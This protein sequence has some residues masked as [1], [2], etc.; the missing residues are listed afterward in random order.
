MLILYLVIP[1]RFGSL[2]RVHVCRTETAGSQ[3]TDVLRI[4]EGPQ[5]KA[6]GVD[7]PK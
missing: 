3:G 7:D 1:A 2:T 5:G 4:G 6:E